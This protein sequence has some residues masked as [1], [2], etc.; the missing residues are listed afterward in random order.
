MGWGPL[1]DEESGHEGARKATWPRDLTTSRQLGYGS[2][3]WSYVAQKLCIGHCR[4]FN[5]AFESLARF[6]KLFY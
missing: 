4:R 1:P 2:L 5:S 3:R 6:S